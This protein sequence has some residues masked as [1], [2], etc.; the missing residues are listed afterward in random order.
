ML[1]LSESV[2]T[3]NESGTLIRSNQARAKGSDAGVE[4]GTDT[5]CCFVPRAGLFILPLCMLEVPAASCPKQDCPFSQTQE[6][7]LT[8]CRPC[9]G[10]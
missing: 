4:L 2:V 6:Q 7:M 3:L 10:R 9:L 1:R 5:A 8:L